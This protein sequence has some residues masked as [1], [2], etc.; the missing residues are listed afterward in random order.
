MREGEESERKKERNRAYERVRGVCVY[1][2]RGRN[3]KGEV[4]RDLLRK[5]AEEGES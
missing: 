1:D 4:E 2:R 5:D 3:L